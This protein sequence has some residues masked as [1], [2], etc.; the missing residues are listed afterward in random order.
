MATDSN[1]GIPESAVEQHSTGDTVQAMPPGA[2]AIAPWWHTAALMLAILAISWS[3]STRVHVVHGRHGHVLGYAASAAMELLLLGWVVLGLWLRKV[4][5]RSLF[6]KV[7]RGLRGLFVDLGVAALFWIVS[8]MA[9]GSLG[10]T[11]NAVEYAVA[12]KGAMPTPGQRMEPSEQQKQTLQTLERMAPANSIEIA[13][14]AALCLLVG[15]VEETIFRG[16]LQRQFAAWGGGRFMVGAAASALIFGAAH[17]YE[18]LRSMVLL[19]AFGALFSGL[20]WLRGGLRAGMIA[21]SAHD[22]IVGLLLAAA[23][24]HHL[25]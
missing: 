9:L 16:Y 7:E 19:V 12:H 15:P 20:V 14:W 23:R 25:I 21:H 6:G 4:P 3:G 2:A 17:G 18:G 8:M 11:W 10:L 5:I 24:A 22:L 1:M 13:C